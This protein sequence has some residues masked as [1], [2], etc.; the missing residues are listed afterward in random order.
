[1][2]EAVLPLLSY[3]PEKLSLHFELNKCL[4]KFVWYDFYH[5]ALD[6]DRTM[7]SFHRH[8]TIIE[9]R[10]ERNPSDNISQMEQVAFT[11]HNPD[12]VFDALIKRTYDGT[13]RKKREEVPE[14]SEYYYHELISR[15]EPKIMVGFFRFKNSEHANKFTK[16]E[17]RIF[18]KFAPHIFTIL[19]TLTLP[20]FQ[21][22]EFRYFDAYTQICSKVSQD[23]A[24]SES[25]SKILPELLLGFTNEEVA[26]RNF[27]STA[28]VKKHLRSI[29][30]KTGAKNRIDFIGKFF[31][32]PERVDLE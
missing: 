11:A 24:F 4:L 9:D 29:F 15:S 25:E 6:E 22:K 16:D 8:R 18:G 17:L 28:T 12:E 5:F 23:Y 10:I 32:S 1:L 14:K 2:Y 19:R 27:V 20:V 26:K 30:K 7:Q 13:V 3:N 21:S 31:T